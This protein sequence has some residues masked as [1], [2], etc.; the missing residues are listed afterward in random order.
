MH[1]YNTLWRQLASVYA[2]GEAKAVVRYVL[3]TAFGLSPADIYCGKADELP[4][5]DSA[6]LAAIMA[7]LQAAEPVQYVLGE[8]EFCGRLFKVGPGVLIPRPETE[9]LCR[10][11]AGS[12][13]STRPAGQVLDLCSGSGC[14]GITLALDLAGAEVTAWDISVEALETASLNAARLGAQVSVARRDVLALPSDSPQWDL[15]VSN[16]PYVCDSER[17]G[18]DRNVLDYEPECALFVPDGDPLRFYHAIFAYARQALKAGG[19]LYFEINPL[20]KDAIGDTATDMDF[21]DIEFKA[22]QFGRTRF[23]RGRKK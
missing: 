6:R 16:P 11:I 8:A 15:M 22:D 14:I 21:K 1:T 17:G 19:W 20:H 7:R 3:E 12:A 13:S 10:W 23:M 18:M 9:E 4:E 5:A 2:P